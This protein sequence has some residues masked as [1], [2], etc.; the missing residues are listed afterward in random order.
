MTKLVLAVIVGVFLGAFA[1]ELFGRNQLKLLAQRLRG[2]WERSK[3][4]A[5]YFRQ[6]FRAAYSS[7]TPN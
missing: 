3:V 1:L 4:S 6:E 7:P 5:Q 2:F